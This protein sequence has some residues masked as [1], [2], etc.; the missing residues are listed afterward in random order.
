MRFPVRKI[1]ITLG[2]A[3]REDSSS[4]VGGGSGKRR[5]L[6]VIQE[7]GVALEPGEAGQ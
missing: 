5:L 2:V 7:G 1:L 3:G 6:A 4:Q